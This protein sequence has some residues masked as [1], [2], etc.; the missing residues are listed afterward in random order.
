VPPSS[1][2][3]TVTVAVPKALGAGVKVR[4]PLAGSIAGWTENR[5]LL[6]LL[7]TS[8][9]CWPTSSDALAGPAAALAKPGTTADPVSSLTVRLA[10]TVST[11]ASL[12]AVTVMVKSCAGEVST[13]PFAVPPLSARTTLTVAV[14][15]VLGAGV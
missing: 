15:L 3:V 5:A 6:S 7:T 8:V 2:R 4:V 12:T 11:G 14:P 13:P 9:S 1:A 10:P